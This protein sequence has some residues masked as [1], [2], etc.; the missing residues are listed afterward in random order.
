MKNI[1]INISDEIYNELW[2]MTKQSGKSF[3]D[4][5]QD[6]LSKATGQKAVYFPN[7]TKNETT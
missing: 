4:V 2:V 7:N 3:S 6:I 5:V 1:N